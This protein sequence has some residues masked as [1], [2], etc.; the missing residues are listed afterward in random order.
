VNATLYLE[1]R[2]VE[3]DFLWRRE[4]FV[5]E[6]DGWATHRTRRAFER[7]RAKDALPLRGGYRA[8]RITWRQ[9]RD[10]PEI[11]LAT[12]RAG[13]AQSAA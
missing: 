3:P 1:N 10:E 2:R 6:T 4:R 11:V 5:V 13:L 7:D 8:A 12:V 9:L